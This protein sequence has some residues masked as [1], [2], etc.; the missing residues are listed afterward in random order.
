MSDTLEGKNPVLEALRAGRPILRIYMS[1]TILRDK[2]TEEIKELARNRN[3]PFDFVERHVLDRKSM[4]KASQ[5]IVAEVGAQKYYDLDEILDIAIKNNAF[6]LILDE[7]EDPGNLGAILRTADAS[8]VHGVIIPK[9]RAVGLTA[10][11]AKAS[12]GAIEYVPVAQV[13]NINQTIDT[14]QEAGIKVV[15]LDEKADKLFSQVDLKVPVAIVIGSE[16]KGI[17]HLTGKK[18]DEIVKIPMLGK[19]AS[20]NASVSAAVMMYEVV[21]QRA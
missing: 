3:V 20:L 16:G 18:C 6:L 7:I 12:A 21:R 17:H 2:A 1:K 13:T 19:I 14:L 10:I 4:T 5:G 15:G 8:G 9:R 11:V